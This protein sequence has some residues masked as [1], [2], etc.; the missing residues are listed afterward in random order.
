MGSIRDFT[1]NL[2][3]DLMLPMFRQTMEDLVYDILNE[4]EVPNRT[5]FAELRDV[6]NSLRAPV[7]GV[8]KSLKKLESRIE[9]IEARLDEQEK[10]LEKQNAPKKI[11][12]NIQYRGD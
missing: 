6:V 5:Q 8:S 2:A 9:Q 12:K 4:R 10:R 1:A 11:R 3:S 7:S